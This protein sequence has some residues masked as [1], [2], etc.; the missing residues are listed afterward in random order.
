MSDD[1]PQLGPTTWG[2]NVLG[3]LV[4]MAVCFLV[5]GG[6]EIGGHTVPIVPLS[7]AGVLLVLALAAWVYGR[8]LRARVRE[9]RISI[10]PEEGVRALVL[11]KVMVF[12]GDLLIG[13][14]LVYVVKF[15]GRMDVPGP[16]ERVIIGVVTILAAGV[17]ALAGWFLERSCVVPGPPPEDGEHPSQ[18]PS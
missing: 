3:G 6:M 16:R 11:G 8:S 13:W 18:D 9:D 12:G 17:F 15:L 1:K 14:H 4:G 7:L 2:Q 5:V 10:T